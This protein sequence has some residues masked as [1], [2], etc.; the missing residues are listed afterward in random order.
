MSQLRYR[1][2]T[3]QCVGKRGKASSRE[4]ALSSGTLLDGTRERDHLPLL[5]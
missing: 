1:I 4:K 5:S 2:F 3:L